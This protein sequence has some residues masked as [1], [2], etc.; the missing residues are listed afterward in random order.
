PAS[1]GGLAVMLLDLPPAASV[2]IDGNVP[3]LGV[4]AAEPG[5][6]AD[7]SPR[8]VIGLHVKEGS[9]LVDL[10][11]KGD[12][13]TFTTAADEASG[14]T[15]LTHKAAGSS[16]TLGVLDNYLLVASSPAD[17]TS[18]GP[19]VARSLPSA[20]AP[21]EDIVLDAPSAAL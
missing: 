19:Y 7:A 2:E 6:A 21:K 11:T 17:L 5:A 18:L 16:G 10:L 13:A 20:T 14:V 15:R 12:K 3:I 8:F 1:T 9:R 4:I